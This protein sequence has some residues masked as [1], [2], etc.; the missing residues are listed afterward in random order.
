MLPAIQYLPE[1]VEDPHAY[2]WQ[3]VRKLSVTQVLDLAGLKCAFFKGDCR[4]RGTAIHYITELIDRDELDQQAFFAMDLELPEK[5]RISGYVSAYQRFLA[6]CQPRVIYCEQ[7][8][9][10]PSIDVCGTIDRA[11]ELRGDYG[12][13]DIKTGSLPKET[14]IQTAGYGYLLYDSIPTSECRRWAL[15]LKKTGKYRLARYD[16][17]EDYNLWLKAVERANQCQARAARQ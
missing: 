12:I 2:Y 13:L 1:F 8:V 15:Q 11:I 7:A 10:S 9:Y 4:D 6:D 16:D 3:G 5:E 14:A 17:H